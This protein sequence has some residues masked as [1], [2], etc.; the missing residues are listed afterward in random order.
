MFFP[1]KSES[2]K[3][4]EEVSSKALLPKELPTLF[5]MSDSRKIK[6]ESPFFAAAED[7]DVLLVF[8]K[9]KLV[10]LYRP[11]DKKIVRMSP[12]GSQQEVM[13]ESHTSD[14]E[15]TISTSTFF[16]KKQN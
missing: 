14:S 3:I 7:G 1:Q 6:E 13:Q 4:F 8:A 15:K 9:S 16:E 11:L 10:I 12:L 5:K 2:Q